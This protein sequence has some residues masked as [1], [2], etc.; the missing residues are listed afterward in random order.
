[1]KV[2]GNKERQKTGTLRNIRSEESS[3]FEIK[4]DQRTLNDL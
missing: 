2:K 4:S 1:M 3:N